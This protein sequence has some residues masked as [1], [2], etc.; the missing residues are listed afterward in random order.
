MYKKKY[1]KGHVVRNI[2]QLSDYNDYLYF[3]NS[4]THA[5]WWQSFQF[6][7]LKK[8]IKRGFVYCADRIDK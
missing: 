1:K 4:L 3:D 5:G 2:K 6:R 7:Y 8:Q